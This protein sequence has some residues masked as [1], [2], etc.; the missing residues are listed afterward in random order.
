MTKF[1]FSIAVARSLEE[2][3]PEDPNSDTYEC[4]KNIILTLKITL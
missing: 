4:V 3:S 1:S 2:R